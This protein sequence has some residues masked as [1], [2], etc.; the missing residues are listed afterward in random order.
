MQQPKTVF[1]AESDAVV[2]A[3]FCHILTRE[4][5]KVQPVMQREELL[6][7]IRDA[8]FDALIADAMLDGVVDTVASVPDRA[9]RIILTTTHPE[10]PA[11]ATH[12]T[13]RKPIEFGLLIDTVRNCVTQ[14]E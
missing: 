3:L 8:Q 1:V 12:A 5:Y 4:G 14:S 13:L 2:L 9:P 10:P 11:V 6:R 7:I